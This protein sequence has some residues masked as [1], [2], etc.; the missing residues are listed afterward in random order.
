MRKHYILALV[1]ISIFAGSM[2]GSLCNNLIWSESQA[3]E[4]TRV[5]DLEQLRIV[6][7]NGKPRV[8]LTVENNEAKIILIDENYKKRFRLAASGEA[9]SFELYN[10]NEQPIVKFSQE[11]ENQPYLSML[12]E[13]EEKVRLYAEA[14][15]ARLKI[16]NES[17]N[18]SIELKVNEG[19]AYQFIHGRKGYLKFGDGTQNTFLELGK[20]GIGGEIAGNIDKNGWCNFKVKHPEGGS[21]ITLANSKEKGSYIYAFAGRDHNAAIGTLSYPQNMSLMG[22]MS[23]KEPYLCIYQKGNKIYGVPDENFPKVLPK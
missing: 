17:K 3:S 11:K 1:V 4:Q 8:L 20:V 15:F 9:P 13:K 10:N 22:I 16:M 23:G 21:E 14:D 6:D 5:L 7:K 2:L 19:Q 18:S 12:S